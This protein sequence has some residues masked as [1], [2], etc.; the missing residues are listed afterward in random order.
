MQERKNVFGLLI[1]NVR[2]PIEEVTYCN[3]SVSFHTEVD[4]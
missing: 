1:E 3:Y 2:E 4:V